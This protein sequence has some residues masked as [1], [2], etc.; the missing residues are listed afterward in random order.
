MHESSWIICILFMLCICRSS[1]QATPIYGNSP[2]F[3]TRLVVA[4]IPIGLFFPYYNFVINPVKTM[5]T[6]NYR[7]PFIALTSAQ[8][9][10]TNININLHMLTEISYTFSSFTI[11]FQFILINATAIRSWTFDTDIRFYYMVVES[12]FPDTYI[13]RQLEIYNSTTTFTSAP[14]SKI[15][16]VDLNTWIGLIPF[17]LSA[18]DTKFI[19]A[20]TSL[21]F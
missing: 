6:Q 3:Q 17:Y 13:S 20:I 2:L 10:Q 7:R 1:S 8:K 16:I 18:A 21:K 11:Q 4:S 19:Y 15:V 9:L 5:S 12:T 14:Q